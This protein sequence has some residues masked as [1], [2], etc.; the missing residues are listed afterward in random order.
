VRSDGRAGAPVGGARRR[1]LRI[2]TRRLGAA[3]GRDRSVDAMTRTRIA[4][5]GAVVVCVLIVAVIAVSS[6]NTDGPR[7]F[8]VRDAS[9]ALLINWTRVGDDVSGSMTRAQLVVP[10]ASRFADDRLAGEVAREVQRESRP[11]SGTVSGDSVRLQFADGLLGS[12]INGRLD[13]DALTLTLTG[14]SGPP[15]LRLTSSTRG[16][17]DVAVQRMRAAET[18]RARRARETREQSDARAGNAIERVATAYEKALDPG[19]QDDP[20]RYMTAAAR[21]DVVANA[22]SDAPAGSCKAI[23]R[24]YER[25]ADGGARPKDLGAA[26]VELGAPVPVPAAPG[27]FGASQVEGAAVRF[28]NVASHYPVPLVMDRGRWR[29]AKYQ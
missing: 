25:Q 9:S 23:V 1:A 4:I 11:F 29:I 26:T 16:E 19:S 7:T 12:R 21:A 22:S 28:A 5:V 8:M 20:C 18:R 27:G 24:F 10:E 3:N 2:R 14:G 17:F 15:T 6:G 13:G